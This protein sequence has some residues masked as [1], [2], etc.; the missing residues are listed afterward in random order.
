MGLAGALLGLALGI[1]LGRGLIGLVS[2]TINDL[3]FAVTI[4]EV[5]IGA[6]PLIKGFALGLLATLAAAA[7]PAFEATYTPPRTVLRRS[8]YEDRVRRIVPLAAG[9][10]A[11][12]LAIGAALLAIPSKDLVLS[13]I[14]LFTITI[15]AA[16]LTPLATLLLMQA[17][18]PVL[19]ALF[20][21]LGRMAAR[22]V[23]ASL[24]RTSVA[25]AALMIAVSVTIGVGLM[26]GSFRHT[27]V[28]WL[29]SSLGSDIY[30]AAPEPGIEPAQHAALARADRAPGQRAG[31]A[32]VRRYHNVTVE[33]PEGPT[34]M[35]A[36]GFR[37]AGS[38]NHAAQ[39]AGQPDAVWQGFAAGE[40]LISEPLAYRRGLQPGDSITLLTDRGEHAF[41]I[42]G[43]YYDYGSDQGIV[44]IALETYR[45]Y[46]NDQ[47]ISS[48]GL[49][50]APGQ[51]VEALVQQLRAI[52]AT[53]TD[54]RRPTTDRADDRPAAAESCC[55]DYR[56]HARRERASWG[57]AAGADPI[58]PGAAR[59]VAG[60]LRPHLCDHQCAAAPG[61]D[62]RVCGH[63]GGADG[64]AARARPRAGHAAGQRPDPGQLW[65]VVMSQTGLM[66]L[67]AG[68]LSL[69]MGV[70]L[71]LV[72]VY[73][74][75]KRLVRLDAAVPARR[76]PVRPGAAGGGGGGAAGRALPG[77]AMS[78]TSPA[79]ALREE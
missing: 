19:G 1:A 12:L 71:A 55:H 25:V 15:G 8:S 65:G 58:E 16:A 78:R 43:V 11:L 3:Y 5:A 56:R 21:L 63:P 7:V 51:D 73:V 60:G 49:D 52:A 44:Q 23:I 69:P 66:G 31:G 22:D 24:S 61:H 32:R 4:R 35:V 28:R 57:G 34:I 20:G 77:L 68:L 42:A 79:L 50:A 2:R 17:A 29:D 45:A 10:G 70:T 47:A 74:I 48:L 18:R 13:F 37:R 64:A 14:A 75:N 59:V 36:R 54:D 6:G 33:S 27:V 76:R 39:T 30:I 46:W 67:T 72:L 9:G 38:R 53:T 41:R 40:L 26:V 62:R